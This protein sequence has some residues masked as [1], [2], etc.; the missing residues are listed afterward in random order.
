MWVSLS[1]H[2]IIFTDFINTNWT[3]STEHVQYIILLRKRER[4]VLTGDRKSSRILKKACQAVTEANLE[5]FWS[6]SKS[7]NMFGIVLILFSF[8][9]VDKSSL[10]LT[11]FI[12]ANW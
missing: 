2:I 9:E 1:D 10:L 5:Q 7:S 3:W 12:F 4:P 6:F 11:T 8:G